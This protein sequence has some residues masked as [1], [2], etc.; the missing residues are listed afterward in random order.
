M[1]RRFLYVR[2]LLLKMT[3]VLML[4][5]LPVSAEASEVKVSADKGRAGAESGANAEREAESRAETE[6]EAESRADTERETG[7]EERKI[8][9]GVF[10]EG[11]SLGGRT[12]AEA[13]A[14]LEA[15]V[16]DVGRY[17]LILD[18]GDDE[19][20]FEFGTLGVSL[21]DRKIIDD[22]CGV[23]RRGSFIQRLSELCSAAGDG[24]YF[25]LAFTCS[26]QDVEALLEENRSA[27]DKAASDASLVRKNGNFVITPE[28]AGRTMDSAAT[29]K[30]IA[31]A[32]EENW[33]S[34]RAGLTV[35]AVMQE[36]APKHTAAELSAVRDR[37]GAYE[38]SF[39]GSSDG[40]AANIRNGAVKLENTVV[41]PDEEYSF[42][43]AMRPFTEENGYHMAGT[44]VNGRNTPGL[45]GGICQVSSTLYNAVLRAEL[46]VTARTNHMMTVGYVPLGADATIANPSTDFK[47][48]NDT[49]APVLIEAYTSGTMLYVRI[50]GRETRP[51]NRTVEFITV[52]EDVV[53]PGADIVTYDDS[54]PADYFYVEQ[55]AHTGYTAAFYKNIYIDG[56]LTEQ[57]LVSRSIYGAYPR[58]VVRG[59]G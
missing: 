1:K 38:T 59:C 35:K 7:S 53:W 56:Y 27:V 44:Y 3:A 36:T 46:T 17:R 11:M 10:A 24:L 18:C 31:R 19:L 28:A 41:Y 34:G 12:E 8:A 48:K 55:N 2:R 9:A 15:F 20:T 54:R 37:L 50:Y 47:F 6:R 4:A 16:D 40:R 22:I 23:C 45:G 25:E 39:A 52:T 30:A 29:A 43:E 21:K 14:M 13:R 57:I 49:G 33:R 32:V 26:I 42:L 58:Y 5:G 51:A